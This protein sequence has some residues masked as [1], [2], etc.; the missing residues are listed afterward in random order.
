MKKRVV[1]L[2]LCLIMALSLIPTA[3]FA[4]EEVENVEETPVVEAQAATDEVAELDFNQS[5]YPHPGQNEH[6]MHSGFCCLGW[7][8]ANISEGT[9]SQTGE[10]NYKI[11]Y[12]PGTDD[13]SS[14]VKVKIV[15]GTDEK[16]LNANEPIRVE[17]Y[18]DN[19]KVVISVDSGYYVAYAILCC[20][21]RSG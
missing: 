1:S 15:N 2:L 20:N 17:N 16:T 21:D 19:A 18:P 8:Y 6:R 3:A 4:T 11:E 14:H 7:N 12:A 9:N 10:A 5:Y 13:L